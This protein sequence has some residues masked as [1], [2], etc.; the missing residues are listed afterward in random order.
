MRKIDTHVHIFP[1][2]QGFHGKGEL[3]P[4][5][6]GMGRWATGEEVRMIPEGLGESSF[7][8][9][10][11]YEFLKENHVEKAV[12]L[13]GNYYGYQNEYICQ[14]ART[15]P[16]MFLAAGIFDPLTPYANR[17]YER[18]TEEMGM[19]VLKF[20][21]STIN[22]LMTYHKAFDLEEV[23]APVA[24]KCAVHGQMMV[25]DI[26]GSD[27]VSFQ[28]EQ[29]AKLADRYPEVNFVV[30]HLLMPAPKAGEIWKKSLELLRKDNV[31]FD[32]AAL[33]YNVNPEIYPYPTAA[34]LTAAA[35]D[36]VGVEH[37]MWGTDLP[38]VVCYDT[39]THLS[40]YLEIS[41]IFTKEELDLIYY[42]NALR[43]YPFEKTV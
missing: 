21:V 20:E 3:V 40:D 22:G 39:Y 9:E 4:A 10:R 32:L 29:I 41:G 6:G 36:I 23:F 14:A 30:C 33:P 25:F 11:C 2:L 8:A 17:I 26:G 24:E 34:G 1:N 15:Y 18:L 28:P 43:V 19:K 7:T 13:Q 5:G 38:S 12:L 35:R 27:T 31:Y 37:I 42:Q 16:D